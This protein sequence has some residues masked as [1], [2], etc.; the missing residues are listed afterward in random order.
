MSE[1]YLDECAMRVMQAI[2]INGDDNCLNDIGEVSYLV[3]KEMLK[4]KKIYG[5]LTKTTTR[6][7]E[8]I[9]GQGKDGKDT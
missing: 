5:K 9:Q 4:A 3:A 1:K 6:T 2:I 8:R 7:K